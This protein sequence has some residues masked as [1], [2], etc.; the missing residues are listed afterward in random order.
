MSSKWVV[1]AV[2]LVASAGCSKS[3]PPSQAEFEK[4]FEQMMTGA[5]LVG[6][7]T[8]LNRDGLSG[9]EKYV[10]ERVSKLAGETW[11]I[12][13]R[14]QYGSHDLPVPVPVTVKW[15]GDTPVITLTDLAIPGMGSYTARVLFYRDQYAGT[16][17]GQKGGGQMFG[18]IVRGR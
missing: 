3:T 12:H 14:I 16:W 8:R 13:A 15:A 9:E 1:A 7:S 11:L 6:R 17:S 4:Q 10:I 5:T 18:K 2:L